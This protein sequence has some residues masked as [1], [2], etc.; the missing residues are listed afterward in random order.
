M[1][2]SIRKR[3]NGLISTFIILVTAA[4]MGLWGVDQLQD[5]GGNDN[6]GAGPAA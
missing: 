6:T 3:T 4:V 5:G 2:D 1:L